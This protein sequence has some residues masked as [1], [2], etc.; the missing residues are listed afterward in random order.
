MDCARNLFIIVKQF[1]SNALMTTV[2]INVIK[3]AGIIIIA[4]ELLILP[5][6]FVIVIILELEAQV[7]V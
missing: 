2:G 4:F 3:Q 6:G 7:E 1:M 5:Y